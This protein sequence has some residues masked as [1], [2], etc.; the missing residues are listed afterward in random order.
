MAN[1]IIPKL[2]VY[3]L[4]LI[5]LSVHEWAHGYLACKLGDPTPA[6]FGRLTLNPLAHIDIIGT[7][8]VPLVMMLLEP[9]FVILGWAK[10]IP[11]GPRHFNNRRKLYEVMVNLVGRF[12]NLILAIFSAIVGSCLVKYYDGNIRE[13]FSLMAFLNVVLFVFNLIPIPPLDGGY[14][15]KLVFWISDELFF[16]ISNWGYWVLI[17]LINI[18]AFHSILFTCVSEVLGVINSLVHSLF[19]TFQG[20]LLYFWQK[21]LLNI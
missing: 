14:I 2:I 16:Q 11:I 13:L 18:P 17:L 1:R 9:N 10:P 4:L 7:V 5:S 21:R 3:L 6:K 20:T 15:L 8:I 19:E 12:S